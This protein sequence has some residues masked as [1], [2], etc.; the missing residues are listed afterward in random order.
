[1]NLQENSCV[2]VIPATLLSL[3]TQ[4]MASCRVKMLISKAK[5]SWNRAFHSPKYHSIFCLQWNETYNGAFLLFSLDHRKAGGKWPLMDIWSSSHSVWDYCTHWV[6]IAGISSNKLLKTM[7]S[8]NLSLPSSNSRP[9]PCVSV[10]STQGWLGSGIFVVVQVVEDH[11]ITPSEPTLYQTKQTFFNLSLCPSCLAGWSWL[12]CPLQGSFQFCGIPQIVNSQTGHK[13]SFRCG[14]I[15]SHRRKSLPLI[16][17]IWTNNDQK[18]Q[19]SWYFQ[20]KGNE[21]LILSSNPVYIWCSTMK[22][23][24]IQI[25]SIFY[26]KEMSSMLTVHFSLK[27]LKTHREG[28]A[29]SYRH[30]CEK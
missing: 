19:I 10:A 3:N 5:S 2:T 21:S 30:F 1:M 14:P 27:P 13:R 17:E 9:F 22:Y 20:I 29:E 7:S 26:S 15:K 25:C 23:D 11:I 16:C 28:S 4:I 6:R 18:F 24:D 8:L 12:S